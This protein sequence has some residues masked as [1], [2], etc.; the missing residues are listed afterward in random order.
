MLKTLYRCAIE[1]FVGD[2]GDS[3][4]YSVYSLCIRAM[5]QIVLATCCGSNEEGWSGC[6]LCCG[7]W[8]ASARA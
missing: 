5:D 3:K 2:M 6:P 1:C 4:F 8:L 7:V